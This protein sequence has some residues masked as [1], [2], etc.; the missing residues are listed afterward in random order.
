MNEALVISHITLNSGH[1]RNSTTAD[2]ILG[3]Q[4]FDAL[5]PVVRKALTGQNAIIP[6]VEDRYSLI[7]GSQGRDSIFAV[8]G[9]SRLFGSKWVPFVEVGIGAGENDA[10]IWKDLYRIAEL[11]QSEVKVLDM[12]ARP[13]CAVMIYPSSV[14]F[15]ASM[16]WL[17]DLEKCLA[18]T[19]LHMI[20]EENDE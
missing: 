16:T 12:P 1:N 3:E 7:G 4:L 11:V 13:W 14:L 5:V 18:W 10:E 19:W 2:N 20:K 8:C 17:G 15:P 9:R 6:W